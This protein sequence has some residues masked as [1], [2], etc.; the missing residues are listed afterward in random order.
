MLSAL[1]LLIL[2]GDG[3]STIVKILI[4]LQKLSAGRS[5]DSF[6]TPIVGGIDT[7]IP[8]SADIHLYADPDSQYT[9]FPRIYVDC[10]GLTGGE[11]IPMAQRF[12]EVDGPKNESKKKLETRLDNEYMRKLRQRAQG[13]KRRKLVFADNEE[14][15]KREYTVR[16]F[17]PRLLYTFSHVVVFVLHNER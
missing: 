3:K 11:K 17:Y 9:Q 13:A 1:Q 16:E 4:E 6:P 12:V 7:S 15:R 2:V 8:T 10:E 5:A 14:T